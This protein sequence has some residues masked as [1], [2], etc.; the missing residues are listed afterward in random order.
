[1]NIKVVEFICDENMAA[2]GTLPTPRPVD[3]PRP[4][5]A[6]LK[7]SRLGTQSF[8]GDSVEPSPAQPPMKHDATT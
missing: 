7:T 5:S 6:D 2:P 8:D 1:M 3:R 4:S